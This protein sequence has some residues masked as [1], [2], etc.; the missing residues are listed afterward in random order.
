MKLRIPQETID[1]WRVALRKA[2][3][4]EIGGVLYGEHVGEA[5]FRIVEITAQTRGGRTSRFKR[6]SRPAIK[7]LR[8]FS[9]SYGQEYKKYNYLGEWHSHPTAP[10][11]PSSV[12]QKTMQ[13]LLAH[14]EIRA[15]FLVLIIVK[16]VAEG[17]EVFAMTFLSS[18]QKLQCN[19]IIE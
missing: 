17:V 3:S 13:E 11:L 9:A 10:V 19:I 18:G 12:D 2:G 1:A 5:D 15:N 16:L 8:K 6:R 4:R 7:A 14:P